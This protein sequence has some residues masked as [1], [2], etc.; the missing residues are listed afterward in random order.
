MCPGGTGAGRHQRP[1]ARP[2]R[3]ADLAGDGIAPAGRQRRRQRDQPRLGRVGE[4]REHRR[5]GGDAGVRDGVSGPAPAAALLGDAE[6]RLAPQS[7]ARGHRGAQE[8][9][10]QQHPSL[11][12]GAHDRSACRWRPRQRARDRHRSRRVPGRRPRWHWPAARS[13][14]PPAAV[15]SA[16]TDQ[17]LADERQRPQHARRRE[18]HRQVVVE[19][20]RH[21]LDRGRDQRRDDGRT[22]REPEIRRRNDRRPA[23]PAQERARRSARDRRARRCRRRSSRGSRATLAPPMRRPTSVAMPSPTARIPHAAATMSGRAGQHQQQQQDRRR[24]E[25]EPGRHRLLQLERPVEA[26][27]AQSSGAAGC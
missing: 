7:Q 27:A 2:P 21:R 4:R 16:A 11:P 19:P 24:I 25:H 14:A 6:Q 1:G 8:R 23:P 5:D 18:R 3:L 15:A 12:A 9:G 26:L 17:I 10:Q 20:D 13:A 22:D